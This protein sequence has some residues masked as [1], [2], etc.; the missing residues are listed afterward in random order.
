MKAKTFWFLLAV[1]AVVVPFLGLL[2]GTS[3]FGIPDWHAESGRALL[4]LRVERVWAGLLVGAALAASGVVLQALLRNPLA[5]PYVLGVSGGSALGA[6]AAILFGSALGVWSVPLSAFLA[7]AAT[8]ALVVRLAQDEQGT[9]SIYGLLLSGVIVSSV[10]SGLLMFLLSIAPAEGVH[11]VLWW[12]LGNL[13]MPSRPLL[14]ACSVLVL[15]GLVGSG[16]LAPELNALTLGGETAHHLG[17]RTKLAV[18]VGLLLATVVTASAVATA[19]LIGFV[20]LVVP[21]VVRSL[22]GP[23]HRRLIPAAALAGGLFLAACDIL[24]RTVLAPREV[25]VGVITALVGGPFF[26]WIL[27]QRRRQGW[28]G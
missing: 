17:V 5:E 22:I 18:A 7:G 28:I 19:G 11:N 3:G 27:R 21:H 9:P 10:C 2:A 14:G 6:A 26:L 25:P 4:M 20:G 15:A 13:Q 8:L 1:L 12:M 16:A 23:D 24:A